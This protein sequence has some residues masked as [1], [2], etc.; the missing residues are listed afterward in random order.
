MVRT[1]SRTPKRCQISSRTAARLQSAKGRPRLIRRVA[2][3]QVADLRLLLGLEKPAVPGRRAPRAGLQPGHAL[4]G[5]A[6]ADIEHP[7]RAQPHLRRNRIIGLARSRAGRSPAAGAPL[8]PLL[9]AC[10]CPHAS[11]RR[12]GSTRLQDRP[13]RIN[14]KKVSVRLEGS[15]IELVPAH[16]I[17]LTSSAP[18]APNQTKAA[19]LALS[20]SNSAVM[21]LH[22]AEISAAVV[23]DAYTVLLRDQAGWHLPDRL[24]VPSNITLFPPRP[25]CPEVRV[26]A[27]DLVQRQSR[28]PAMWRYAFVRLRPL[29]AAAF[30]DHFVDLALDRV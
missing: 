27:G 12:L 2:A 3:D 24:E 15:R 28:S 16:S 18:S 9:A 30:L 29:P 7:G 8:A 25:K 20:Q 1:A 11:C 10:A 17:D 19:G 21:T 14:N 4:L 6:L 26:L 23:L 22:H 5:E 13:G